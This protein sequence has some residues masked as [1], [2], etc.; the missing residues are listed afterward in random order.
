MLSYTAT[1]AL[2]VIALAPLLSYV[3]L[4]A[5]SGVMISV[6]FQTV[7]WDSM[8]KDVQLAL[9]DNPDFLP[10]I[11]LIVTSIACYTTNF[12]TGVVV[13]VVIEQGEAQEKQHT[14]YSH[15]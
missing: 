3:S 8:K 15:N 12:G 5:L 10:L 7:Q 9:S 13:G 4:A 11:S 2:F 14:A 6:C 1:C